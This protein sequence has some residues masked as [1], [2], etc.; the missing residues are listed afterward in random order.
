MRIGACL[1]DLDGV[2]VDTAHY[3]YEAWRRLARELGFEF[4]QQQNEALKGVSRMTSLDILLGAGGLRDSFSPEEKL[5]MATRK[6]EW[7]VDM[8]SRM[9]PY[10][11]LPG[12]ERF[13]DEVR[14]AGIKIVLGSASRNAPLILDK[15]GLT[16]Y[17][18]AVVDGSMV[19]A[20]K[21]DPAVFLLGAALAK[22]DPEECVVF[23]DAEAGIE[24][25][26]RAGMRSV[27]VGESETLA[28][29]TVRIRGFEDFT[30]KELRWLLL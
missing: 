4:S 25:A 3:H 15:T 21:P 18:D 9:T 26:T 23:E 19:D 24:A 17:F 20:A 7:Y 6:N 14:D 22:T 28:G 8:I 2:L 16:R 27:G 10:E 1:F 29:A 11:I 30:V 13:L 5:R 12:V